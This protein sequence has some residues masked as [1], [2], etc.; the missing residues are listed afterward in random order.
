M[1]GISLLRKY[2]PKDIEITRGI[3][4]LQAAADEVDD[5]PRVILGLRTSAELFAEFLAGNPG[6]NIASIVSPVEVSDTE[7]T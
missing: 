7:R 6:D 2:F 5:G 3:R 1:R 4:Y